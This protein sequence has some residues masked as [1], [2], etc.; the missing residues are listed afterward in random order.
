MCT[1]KIYIYIYIYIPN[2]Y[3]IIL[4][5]YQNINCHNNTYIHIYFNRKCS[6]KLYRINLYIQNSNTH[7]YKFSLFFFVFSFLYN[8]LEYP[9]IYA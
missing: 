5:I 6:Y 7:C 4:N 1:Q 9:F 8:C 2:Y 3:I